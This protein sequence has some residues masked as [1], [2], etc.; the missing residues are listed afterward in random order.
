M[1]Y[2]TFTRKMQQYPVITSNEI[3]HLS[4]NNRTLNNQ[5]IYWKKQ[6]KI[7][8]LKRGFY[9]LNEDDRKVKLTLLLISNYI[10]SPSY[11]S[12][13]FALSYYGLIPEPVYEITGISTL[14][15]A[16]FTNSYGRFSYKKT[17]RKAFFGYEQQKDEAG[18]PILIATREKAILD[19]I[20]FDTN[21][22]KRADY[23]TKNLR[24]QNFS[25][26]NLKRL[27]H[28]ANRFSSKK[29]KEMSKI[30]IKLIKE[31]RK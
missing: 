5:I 20:Y 10:Y 17:K 1:N 24:L 13:D 7:I 4:K 29:V 28:F 30:L 14:K 3:K 9:T 16:L 23:F 25:D 6:G 8:Q 26:L 2:G 11:V 21:V 27:A 31:E 18:F 22:R 19:K 12:L 15:T